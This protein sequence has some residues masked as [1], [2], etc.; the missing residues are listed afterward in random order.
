MTPKM[1]DQYKTHL[2]NEDLS[3]LTITGYLADTR[4]FIMWF[5]K[6]NRERFALENVTPSDVREYRQGLQIE[7][8]LKASTVNRKLASLS[9]LMN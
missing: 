1:I 6:H 8:G 4:L 9:S 2:E 7:Q 3:V 5:E